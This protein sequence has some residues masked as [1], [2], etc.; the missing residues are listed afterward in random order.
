M[1]R[2]EVLRTLAAG[3]AAGALAAGAVAAVAPSAEASVADPLFALITEHR[4]QMATYNASSDLSS[5]EED[6]FAEATFAPSWRALCDNPPAPTTMQGAL[7]ALRLAHEEMHHSHGSFERP[8]V[9]VALAYF[10]GRV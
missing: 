3:S 2:R 5:E 10:E 6:A 1:N 9:G 8:L 7:E 4:A